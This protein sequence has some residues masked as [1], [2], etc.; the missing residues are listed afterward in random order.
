MN[1]KITIKEGNL[2]AEKDATFIVNA[3]NTTMILGSGV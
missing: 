1:Y 2:L 3:S